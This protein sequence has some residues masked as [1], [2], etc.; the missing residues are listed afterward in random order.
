MLKKTTKL[1]IIIILLV[2]S[3]I[4]TEKV[5]QEAKENDPVMK[6]I[7]V[8]KKQNDVMP[9]EPVIKNSSIEIGMKGYVVNV[10]S[11]Y[12]NMKEKNI[13]DENKIVK[14]EVLPDKS[15]KNNY[16]YYITRGNKMNKNVSII[17]K[18]KDSKNLSKLI[19]FSNNNDISINY[20][21]DGKWLSNNIEDM[22]TINNKSRIYNLGYDDKYDKSSINITN[23]LIES[24]TLKDSIFCLNDNKNDD[25]LE[26]CEKNK[27]YSIN[28]TL[29][30]PSIL[31]LKKGLSKGA[32]ISFDL[33]IYDTSLLNILISTIKNKGYNIVSL[34]KLI[35]E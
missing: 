5:T 33:D 13:F 14:K 20:F 4:F 16:S 29:K 18:I 27:M 3:F 22:L 21:A 35:K 26:I 25:Y 2:F 19:S 1:I 7:K 10:N 8:Y 12:K 32:I 6:K 17:F 28:P 34:D 23:T 11:S 15:I 30:N 31:K 24:I 9:V